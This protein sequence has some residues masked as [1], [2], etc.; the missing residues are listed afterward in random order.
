M[1]N[2][3][4]KRVI[5]VGGGLAGMAAAVAL[6]SAG[7]EVTLLEARRTLGGRAGSFED[8][9]T[10]EILDNCQHVLLGCCTNLID[11]YRRIGAEALIRFHRAIHF[12]DETGR[13]FDLFGVK[14]FPAPFHLAPALAGFSA[15]T[16]YERRKLTEAMLE[17]AQIGREGRQRL[18]GTAFGDWLDEQGQPESLVQKFYDAVV[19]SGLNEDTRRA[20]AKYAIQIFQE[21]LIAN[22]H[23]YVV[24]MP[25]CPL[26]ELYRKIPV[27]DVRFGTRVAEIKFD[28]DRIAGIELANGET[29]VADAYVLAT[30]HHAV[31]KWMPAEMAK[32]DA[33]F[34]RLDQ[35]ESVPILGVHLWFDRPVLKESHAAMMRGPLQWVFRKD[36]AGNAVH[37][38][39]SAA[40]EWADRSKDEMLSL[41][42]KQVRQTFSEARDAKLLRGVVVIE[43]RATFS[44]LPRIDRIRPQQS[45][46][47]MGIQNLFLAGD[48]TQ[49]GWPATMEGAVRSGYL[50][51]DAILQKLSPDHVHQTFLIDDLP[52]QWPARLLGYR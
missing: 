34:A 32:T 38:V 4:I 50:A 20:S 45:P 13:R 24:G 37:G 23:G 22:S 41:F 48:Y 30:N 8:P 25:L 14:Q 29:L 16:I 44:P 42:E 31:Q 21:S 12:R 3:K 46:P 10:G 18:D 51:A 11:F 5:V 26:G 28:R 40:R 47:P 52:I 49:T 33:R 43:K 6:E 9:Q 1:L 7:V 2:S 15:L 39:I 35:F 19:I 27:R 36:E 17:M